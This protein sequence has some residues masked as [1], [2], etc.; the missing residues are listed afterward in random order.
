MFFFFS[1][2]IV[3]TAMLFEAEKEEKCKVQSV[4]VA[5]FLSSEVFLCFFVSC[6][7]FLVL[8]THLPE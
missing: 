7:F 4:S 6:V 1:K 3:I 8:R 5:F 2:I